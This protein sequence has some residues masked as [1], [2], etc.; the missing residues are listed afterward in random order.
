M[1]DRLDGGCACGAVRYRLGTPPLFVHCC[2]CRDCQRQSGSAFTINALIEADRCAVLTG[3]ATAFAM[4]T[5]SGKPHHIFRCTRCG[6]ALWSEYGGRSTIRFVRAATL[7]DPAA[8][9]PDVHIYTRSKLPWLALP[10]GVPA[11]EAYYDSRTLWP[12][13]SLER[14]RAL[15]G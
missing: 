1:T 12:A 15:R 7:D 10:D 9:A 6:T 5:D 3:E 8:L 14:R 2:H 4:P 11:F 13:A